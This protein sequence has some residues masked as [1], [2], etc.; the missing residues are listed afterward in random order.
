MMDNCCAFTGHRPHKLPWR[1]DETDSRCV[2]LKKALTEQITALAKAGIS[3]PI[4]M[5][6]VLITTAANRFCSWTNTRDNSGLPNS[7]Y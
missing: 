1:Y 6:A 7:S 2:A 4:T 3:L 5:A